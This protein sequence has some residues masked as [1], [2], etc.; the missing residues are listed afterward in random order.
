MQTKSRNE[1]KRNKRK[2][3]GHK[4][5]KKTESN[6]WKKR[7]TLNKIGWRTLL[8][9]L[10][11]YLNRDLVYFILEGFF[12]SYSWHWRIASRN[13]TRGNTGINNALY[14]S[15]NTKISGIISMVDFPACQFCLPDGTY[16]WPVRARQACRLTYGAFTHPAWDMVGIRGLFPKS[17][18]ARQKRFYMTM[19]S[20]NRWIFHFIFMENPI[21]KWKIQWI[22]L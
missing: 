15:C 13:M 17:H 8:W 12:K 7:N 2:T 20:Q 5:T 16:I 9:V 10:V 18:G 3:K 4:K 14:K 22:H 19:D 1:K 11:I 21:L 6:K